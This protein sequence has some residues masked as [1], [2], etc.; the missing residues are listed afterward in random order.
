MEKSKVT[1]QVKTHLYRTL[2]LVQ[3]VT[4]MSMEDVFLVILELNTDEKVFRFVD[5][6]QTKTVNNVI[7]VTTNQV[8]K[9]ATWI[10]KRLPID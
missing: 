6:L 5:W 1:P 2:H 8:L 7:K 3:N 10:N 4:G 9:A